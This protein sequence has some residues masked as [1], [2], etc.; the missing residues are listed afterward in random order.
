MKQF[1]I[2]G[3][4]NNHFQNEEIL[5]RALEA[6]ATNA[7]IMSRE[8]H[9]ECPLSK[10]SLLKT[11]LKEMKI[12]DIKVKEASVIETTVMQSG[13]GTDH[14]KS[15]TV[16]LA[17]ASKLSSRKLLSVSLAE[18]VTIDENYTPDFINKSKEIINKILDRAGVT[19]CLASVEINRNPR[20]FDQAV[21]LATVSALVNTNG[22]VQIN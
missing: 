12:T 14:R 10:L 16:Y 6:G 1:K 15:V 20:D 11:T 17:P 3:T 5:M 18:G 2:S 9:V 22:I 4:I 7:A 13:T 19:H 8:I 21:E